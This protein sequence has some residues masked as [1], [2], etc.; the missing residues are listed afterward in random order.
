MPDPLTRDRVHIT[1]ILFLAAP[2]AGR[3]H[4]RPELLSTLWWM[5]SAIVRV[6]RL[7]ITADPP[8]KPRVQS[9]D[10]GGSWWFNSRGRG[11]M[12]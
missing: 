8:I 2:S 11:S 5:T 1:V 6:R 12:R 3:K 7:T 10:G 4:Y 9:E